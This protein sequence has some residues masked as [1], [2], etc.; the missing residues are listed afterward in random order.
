[1]KIDYEIKITAIEA[2]YAKRL[3]KDEKEDNEK[4]IRQAE[5]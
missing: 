3:H 1:M 2:K 4:Q 5:D